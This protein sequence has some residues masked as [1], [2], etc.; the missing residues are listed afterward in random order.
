MALFQALLAFVSRSAGKILYAVFGWAVRAL[1]GYTAGATR[2]LLTGLVALAALWPLLMVGVA[3]PRVAAF[4]VAFV[5]ISEGIDEGWLRAGWIAAALL[6]PTLVGIALAKR[7]RSDAPPESSWKRVARGYPITLG[8]SAAFWISFVSV[9]LQRLASLARGLDDAYVPLITSRSSYLQAAERVVRV[10]NDHGFALE[11]VEPGFWTRAPL[12]ILRA[13][14][15]RALR[16]FVPVRLAY[17][18]GEALLLALFPSGLL[19]RGRERQTALAHGLAVEALTNSDAYQTTSAEAQRLEHEIRRVWRVLDENRSAHED[20]ASLLDRMHEI[21]SDL[22]KLDVP[23]DDWQIVY[24]QILQLARA[25]R[26]EPQIL[27]G[28]DQTT[29]GGAMF[30]ERDGTAGELHANGAG[31]LGT[32][33][34]LRQITAKSAL[35]ARKEIELARTEIKM[36][37]ESVLTM[38]KALGL[39]GVL[40]VTTLNLLLVGAVF[41]LAPYMEGWLAALLLAGATLLVAVAV[42]VF[43]WKRRVRRPLERTRRT[44]EEDAKWAKERLA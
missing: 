30:D 28:K 25:L 34:L 12:G 20:S 43:G 19:L 44:L 2:M 32:A 3:F 14:G 13:L 5:P 38:G 35:L 11:A 31:E 17:F 39:A 37:F 22:T 24:R 41:G 15:G 23:Y 36:D 29:R 27:G 6:V 21:A 8:I 18:R 1:F 33:E 40:A 42:G 26:G 10:L 7:S 4:A 16:D 9:P